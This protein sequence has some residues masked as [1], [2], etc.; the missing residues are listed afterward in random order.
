MPNGSLMMM[1]TYLPRRP[2]IAVADSD[3]IQAQVVSV[4]LDHHGF[5]MVRFDTGE[6]LLAWA[7]RDLESRADAVLVD[8]DVIAGTGAELCDELRSLPAY[9]DT[10]TLFVGDMQA[11]VLEQRARTAGACSALTKDEDL[12]PRLTEWLTGLLPAVVY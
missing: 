6:E 8:V 2:L 1:K 3:D 12:L 5:D 4:W 7:Q 10:P 11:D 9:R